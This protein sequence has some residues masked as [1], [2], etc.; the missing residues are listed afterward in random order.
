VSSRKKLGA[1]NGPTGESQNAQGEGKLGDAKRGEGDSKNDNHQQG[2]RQSPTKS[3]LHENPAVGVE[4]NSQYQ[5]KRSIKDT[6]RRGI[7]GQRP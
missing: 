2:K 7:A 5:E 6:G 1:K 4:P 3:M